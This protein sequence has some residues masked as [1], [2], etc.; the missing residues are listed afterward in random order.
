MQHY[1]NPGVCQIKNEERQNPE[2]SF[3]FQEMLYMFKYLNLISIRFLAP[4]DGL[5][6]RFQRDLGF[7][8][9]G[10]GKVVNPDFIG[11]LQTELP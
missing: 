5:E 9:T 3:A 11:T 2:I 10:P 1:E 7:A 6:S 8:S 4:R